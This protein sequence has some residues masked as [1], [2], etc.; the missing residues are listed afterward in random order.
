M[1]CVSDMSNNVIKQ[2]NM[3]I[4]DTT[5]R[6]GERPSP[7]VFNEDVRRGSNGY[8]NEDGSFEYWSPW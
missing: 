2:L 3:F 1:K 5:S 7:K 8:F 6:T 4:I